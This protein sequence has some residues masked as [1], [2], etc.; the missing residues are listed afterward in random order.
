MEIN[1]FFNKY[2]TD[3]TIYCDD[4]NLSHDYLNEV[5]LK[6]YKKFYGE[7]HKLPAKEFYSYVVKSLWN[8]V[9]D[10]KKSIKYKNTLHYNTDDVSI[11]AQVEEHLILQS[12]YNED[13]NLYNEEIEFLTRMLFKYIKEKGYDDKDVYIIKSYFLENKMTYHK[14]EIKIGINISKIK[15]V[16]RGF[17][18]DVKTNFITWLNNKYKVSTI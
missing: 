2:Y 17:K 6:M 16:I 18:N 9:L 12:R 11:I 10:E 8:L 5:Y 14:L 15:R 3:L 1:E 13:D 4:K 7:Q